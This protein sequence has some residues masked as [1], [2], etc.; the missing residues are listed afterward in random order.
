MAAKILRQ[1]SAY[2][3][4]YLY[5]KTS[6]LRQL[7]LVYDY[8]QNDDVFRSFCDFLLRV[9]DKKNHVT[10]DWRLN[11]NPFPIIDRFSLQLKSRLIF[12]QWNKYR[13]ISN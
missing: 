13:D 9:I 8:V 11:E 7:K 4:Y 6:G 5:L 2:A 12:D 10:K 3:P 1:Q